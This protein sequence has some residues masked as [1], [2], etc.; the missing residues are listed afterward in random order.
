MGF[1]ATP[2]RRA[3]DPPGCDICLAPADVEHNEMY[4]C[5]GCL[6]HHWRLTRWAT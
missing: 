1:V 6:L 5:A 4:W 2:Q 3:S